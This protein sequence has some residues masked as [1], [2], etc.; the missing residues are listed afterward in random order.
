MAQVFG[1]RCTY[2]FPRADPVRRYSDV[3]VMSQMEACQFLGFSDWICMDAALATTFDRT[4]LVISLG[5]VVA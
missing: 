4:C 3:G 2:G 5:V 1:L